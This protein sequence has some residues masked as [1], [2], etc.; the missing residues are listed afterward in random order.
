MKKLCVLM[1]LM[2]LFSI[3]SL[4]LS[5]GEAHE[6]VKYLQK[7]TSNN[8]NMSLYKTLKDMRIRYIPSDIELDAGEERTVNIEV[9]CKENID[10][11]IRFI[12]TSNKWTPM[13]DKRPEHGVDFSEKRLKF[14]DK[15][16]S[17]LKSKTDTVYSIK[18]NKLSF[19]KDDTVK[20]LNM[21]L[22]I[23]QG[24]Y[25]GISPL[26]KP[27]EGDYWTVG[28]GRYLHV[29]EP[30]SFIFENLRHIIPIFVFAPVAYYTL[31]IRFKDGLLSLIKHSL[32]MIENIL[33]G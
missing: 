20:S 2:L 4:G 3:P 10:F 13:F 11:K 7:S 1:I 15:W 5:Q 16:Y 14:Y 32:K 30:D 12:L 31:R 33:K 27:E 17:E 9:T 28:P 19:S 25:F 22:K 23:E 18:N 21:S 6:G 29:E 8:V 24:G 26:I